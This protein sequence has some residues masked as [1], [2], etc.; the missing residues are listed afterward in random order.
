MS[1]ATGA[2]AD[3]ALSVSH[4][5]QLLISTDRSV[6]RFAV[7]NST[8]ALSAKTLLRHRASMDQVDPY[9]SCLKSR[10]KTFQSTRLVASPHE[11]TASVHRQI[12]KLTSRSHVK[13]SASAGAAPL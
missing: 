10:Y 6:Q 13:D 1:F 11:S 9:N 4:I 3:D 5:D 2:E 7:G 12:L 8:V